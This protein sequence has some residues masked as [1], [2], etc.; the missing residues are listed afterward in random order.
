MMAQ[1]TGSRRNARAPRTRVM[2]QPEP[3]AGTE[4]V[5]RDRGLDD[6]EVDDEDRQYNGAVDGANARPGP[7]SESAAGDEQ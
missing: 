5:W 7:L 3:P 6:R 4:N 2:P 1:Q